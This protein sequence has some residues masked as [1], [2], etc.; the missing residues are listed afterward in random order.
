MQNLHNMTAEDCGVPVNSV[1]LTGDNLEAMMQAQQRQATQ[2]KASPKTAPKTEKRLGL[3]VDTPDESE[4]ESDLTDS[5]VYGMT[6]FD[7][8]P[9]IKKTFILDGKKK[10]ITF[11]T[12]GR[13]DAEAYTV[14]V[15][16]M[17]G[18]LP[19]GQKSP[20][21]LKVFP[22]VGEP[23]TLTDPVYLG[24]LRLIAKVCPALPLTAW[25]ILGRKIGSKGKRAGE[26][27]MQDIAVYAF[28]VS[29][30]TVAQQER[31][32]KQA[33]EEVGKEA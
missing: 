2:A 13:T 3:P 26:H 7:D 23:F 30:L 5:D 1:S 14:L 6:G 19:N 31:E 8:A 11:S 17:Q 33:G 29:G 16:A 25:A 10:T 20:K 4:D 28:E 18:I 24:E 21:T 15:S 12:A 27:G 32:E 9:E 22:P